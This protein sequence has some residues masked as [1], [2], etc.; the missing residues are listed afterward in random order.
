MTALSGLK[1]NRI[2]VTELRLSSDWGITF[3]KEGYG[4]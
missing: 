4:K 2:L 1:I 3:P